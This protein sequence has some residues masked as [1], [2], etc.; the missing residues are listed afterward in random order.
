[1]T[2]ESYTMI[3]FINENTINAKYDLVDEAAQSTLS[4][5]VL[6]NMLKLTVGKYSKIDFS[7][8]SKSKGNFKQCSF[9]RN[10][11]ECIATLDKINKV[12]GKLEL[13]G[14]VK[15]ALSNIETFR[16]QFEAGFRHNDSLT[17]MMY[18]SICYAVMEIV[19]YLLV[20]SLS[21]TKKLDG[22][23]YVVNVKELDKKTVPLVSAVQSFNNSCSNGNIIKFFKTSQEELNEC[24]GNLNEESIGEWL[25][26]KGLDKLS[27]FYNNHDRGIKTTAKVVGIGIG[28]VVLLALLIPAIREIIYWIYRCRHTI[29]ESARAQ[30]EFLKC[31]VSVLEA[32]GADEKV[33]AKQKAAIDRFENIAN[34]IGIDSDKANRD[35]KID[36]D[37]DKIDASAIVF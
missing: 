17:I 26:H 36:I 11:T 25:L 34:K 14:T 8:I 31:N 12:T 32:S 19:T 35:T 6:D 10:L 27:D 5:A 28:V 33:I 3:R 30:A 1:M 20:A 18:N 29:A 9:Y 13:I 15:T 22:Q 23:D 37:A 21:F 2:N 4:N 24:V 7:E 16:P